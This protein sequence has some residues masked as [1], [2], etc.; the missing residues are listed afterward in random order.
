MAPIP[1]NSSYPV[2]A[3]HGRFPFNQN[4]PLKIQLF[5]VANGTAFS[6]NSE[7]EDN[8]ARYTQIFENF[9]PE[10]FLPFYFAP[11][12]SRI[13]GWM[14]RISEIQQFSEFLETIQGNFW[15][16]VTADIYESFGWMKAKELV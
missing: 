12:I 2:G 8:L 16:F 13:F 1:A 15:T 5:P 10:V 14:V 7:K 11:G 6:K 3:Y 4:A 9:V